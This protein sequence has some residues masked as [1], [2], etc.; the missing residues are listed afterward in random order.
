MDRVIIKFGTTGRNQLPGQIN[1]GPWEYNLLAFPYFI[2][3]NL[4]TRFGTPRFN[5]GTARI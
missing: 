5:A 4:S 1:F 2:F 3:C